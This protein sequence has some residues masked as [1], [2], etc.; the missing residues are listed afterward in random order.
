MIWGISIFLSV[1]WNRVWEK[2]V[3]H[4]GYLIH[5]PTHCMLCLVLFVCAGWVW[6]LPSCIPQLIHVPFL[7]RPRHPPASRPHSPE[8]RH[9]HPCATS[10]VRSQPDP[11]P[12]TPQGDLG[13]RNSPPPPLGPFPSWR[14][15]HYV[16]KAP[17]APLQPPHAQQ[18]H[19]LLYRI[20][21]GL[22]F[23]RHF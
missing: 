13:S 21:Q 3:V 15:H 11:S 9:S 19:A 1:R 18:R 5:L 12:L 10:T 7:H 4:R 20:T 14:V 17:P 6:T 8:P 16:R 2:Q 23:K 22:L